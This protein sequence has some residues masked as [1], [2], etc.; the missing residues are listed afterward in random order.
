MAAGKVHVKA[1]CGSDIRRFDVDGW[2]ELERTIAERFRC[3]SAF[4]LTYT[5]DEG[6]RITFDTQEEFA[7]AAH[8]AA[9]GV[10][11]VT[12]T[13]R[14]CCRRT[15]GSVRR[16]APGAR[17][18]F[19]D[20]A[21][22]AGRVGAAAAAAPPPP[23]ER[24]E[25]SDGQSSEEEE[26]PPAA[27]GAAR[28]TAADAARPTAGPAPAEPPAPAELP[29]ALPEEDVAAGPAGP[30]AA[31][32]ELA[33]LYAA[34]VDELRDIG[35]A[36]EDLG[37][38]CHLLAMVDGDV[39]LAAEHLRL[40]GAPAGAAAAD[41][42]RAAR[43]EQLAQLRGMGFGDDAALLAALERCGGDVA[44]AA[45]ALSGSRRGE[46]DGEAAPAPAA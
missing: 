42:E 46:A 14:R 35:F 37:R 8:M 44:A 29:P 17:V 5:D 12:V 36:Q 41:R 28:P 3:P 18:R 40:R 15:A 23:P 25:S 34:E 33:A 9:G 30:D 31:H 2:Q 7:E 45:V 39:Q 20:E 6:D 1:V 11:R 4:T 13:R 24:P 27:A 16:A 43:A 10:L 32:A 19:A 38:L 21:A 26:Q 22:P